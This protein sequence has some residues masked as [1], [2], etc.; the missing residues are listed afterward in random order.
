[1]MGGFILGGANHLGK[2]MTNGWCT[3]AQHPT[4][5]SNRVST[6]ASQ[7]LGTVFSPLY[8]MAARK[9]EVDSAGMVAVF[10][11]GRV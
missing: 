2:D 3:G 11:H 4:V 9:Y 1:M 5:R 6:W 10:K 7:H 8:L